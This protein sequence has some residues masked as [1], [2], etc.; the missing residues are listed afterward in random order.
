[1]CDKPV[2][3]Y[4]STI[5]LIPECLIAQEMCDK[6]VNSCFLFLILCLIYIKLKKCQVAPFVKILLRYYLALYVPD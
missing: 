5:K 3:T 1:M 4:P 6:V 2:N